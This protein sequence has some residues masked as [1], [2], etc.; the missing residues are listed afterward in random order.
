VRSD[1]S[2]LP[3]LCFSAIQDLT[4]IAPCVRIFGSDVWYPVFL[5]HEIHRHLARQVG[6]CGVFSRS[7]STWVMIVSCVF[8]FVLSTRVIA[9]LVVKSLMP[10][11]PLG[12]SV[13]RR[14][15]TLALG[16]SR[17][18]SGPFA[19]RLGRRALGRTSTR[20]MVEPP[21]P[22]SSYSATRPMFRQPEVMGVSW[23]TGSQWPQKE[24]LTGGSAGCPRNPS[25][26]RRISVSAS[27][28][29]TLPWGL[30][31]RVRRHTLPSMAS[32]LGA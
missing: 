10:W 4:R 13:S 31:Q 7:A 24:R 17:R 26:P 32:S 9:K 15:A 21:I 11:R 20:V 5:Q 14:S 30:S 25:H 16:A 22:L 23:P 2:R 19:V 1:V 18:S 6:H 3:S 8:A 27:S 28:T 29:G 12:K